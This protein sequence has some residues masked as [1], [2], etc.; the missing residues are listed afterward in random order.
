MSANIFFGGLMNPF[1]IPQFPLFRHIAWVAQWWRL[2]LIGAIAFIAFTGYVIFF[3]SKAEAATQADVK[4]AIIAV[5]NSATER[6]SML[7]DGNETY[8]VRIHELVLPDCGDSPSINI[9]QLSIVSSQAAGSAKSVTSIHIA[10]GKKDRS[11]VIMDL[12]ADGIVDHMIPQATPASGQA[13]F[14][15]VIACAAAIR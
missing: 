3:A 7:V 12:D 2:I 10:I 8:L 9:G 14:D 11:T 6:L 5:Q 15:R 4:K 1:G 13:A